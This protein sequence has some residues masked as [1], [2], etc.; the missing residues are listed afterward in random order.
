M[1]RGPCVL[2]FALIRSPDTPALRRVAEELD[3]LLLRIEPSSPVV[4]D[5]DPDDLLAQDGSLRGAFL[6][7]VPP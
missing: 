5:T 6:L 2:L 1:D 7:F 4:E 3:A